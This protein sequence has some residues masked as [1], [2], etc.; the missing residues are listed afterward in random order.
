MVNSN[1][2]G[3]HALEHHTSPISQ[4]EPRSPPREHDERPRKKRRKVTFGRLLGRHQK[5]G[6]EPVTKIS[7]IEEQETILNIAA[8]SS[9]CQFLRQKCNGSGKGKA[10]AISRHFA[11]LRLAE[12]AHYVFYLSSNG[13]IS[14]N[15][16]TQGLFTPVPLTEY[17]DNHL[18]GEVSVAQQYKL[19]LKLTQ[20]VLQFQSTPWFE[21]EWNMRQLLVLP[22][23]DGVADNL[24][25]YINS[26]LI[27]A[28]SD[29][30]QIEP[31]ED[32]SAQKVHRPANKAKVPLSAAQRRGVD[33]ITLFCLGVALLEIA[34]WKPISSLREDYDDDS[35]DTARR[36]ANGHS[37]LGKWYDETIRKCLRCD[38]AF[39]TDL[40]RLELQRAV[41]GEVICPLE[42]LIERLD[43]LRL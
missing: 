21:E 17:L 41:Y 26:K 33:N 13:Y 29:P 19:A 10:K 23:S 22:E 15:L 4:Q 11:L 31:P 1:N 34:H 42:D 30:S 38:F 8:L 27:K 16:M 32:S 14:S 24:R 5:T 40:R 20:A 43:N 18:Q 35:I 36:M 39:G 7:A 3:N 2:P 9:A 28:K 25:V 6:E 12:E 37:L